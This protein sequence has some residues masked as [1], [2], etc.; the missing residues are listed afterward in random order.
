MSIIQHKPLT[1]RFILLQCLDR[2]E[3]IK[4]RI[5]KDLKEHVDDVIKR[6]NEVSTTKS[7][8]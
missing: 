7:K 8:L 3:E 4:K 1:I 5:Y 2:Q 6:I